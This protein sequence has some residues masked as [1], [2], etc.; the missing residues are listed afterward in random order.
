MTFSVYILIR[1]ED[2]DNNM[3][4]DACDSTNDRDNDGVPDEVFVADFLTFFCWTDQ[5]DSSHPPKPPS[6]RLTTVQMW[7][8]LT[9]SM[10]FLVTRTAL[11]MPVMTMTTTMAFLILSTTA[12][13]FLITPSW[14]LLMSTL[15]LQQFRMVPNPDQRDSNSDGE[16]I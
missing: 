8:T 1:Q 3:V 15:Q 5:R 4:G 13:W 12:G 14:T 16:G 10:G 11:E 7:E 9:S 2:S 6:S